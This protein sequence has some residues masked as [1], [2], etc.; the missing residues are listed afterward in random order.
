M[1]KTKLQS[2]IGVVLVILSV[3]MFYNKRGGLGFFV[4]FIGLGLY[5]Y[6]RRGT[7]FKSM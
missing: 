7:D 2:T 5:I 4:F 6:S 3:F 1:K